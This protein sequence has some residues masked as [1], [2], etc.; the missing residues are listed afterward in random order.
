M[1]DQRT[2]KKLRPKII[3]TQQKP[4]SCIQAVFISFQQTELQLELNEKVAL[5]KKLRKKQ[6]NQAKCL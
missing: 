1:K 5:Q 4:F 6:I 2:A 3:L